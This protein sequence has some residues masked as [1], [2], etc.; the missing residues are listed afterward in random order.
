[1]FRGWRIQR[2][3]AY[4]REIQEGRGHAGRSALIDLVADKPA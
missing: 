1:A 2:L 3:A 4:E